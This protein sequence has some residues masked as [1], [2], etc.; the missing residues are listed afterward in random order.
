MSNT[1]S[2]LAKRTSRGLRAAAGAHGLPFN[3]R[4]PLAQSRTALYTALTA[5]HALRRAV[6]GL[7]DRELAPLLALRAAGGRLDM[8]QFAA[9]FG[10]LQPYR[11]WRS[12]SPPHP[13]R[14]PVST[15]DRLWYLGLIE[16]TRA[17]VLLPAEVAA[18]L[19][20]PP[21]PVPL[22]R[23][24]QAVEYTLSDALCTDVAAFIGLLMAS[25]V[26]PL[27]GR[28]LP[29]LAL[30]RINAIALIPEPLHGVRSELQTTRLRFVH[31]LA[32]AAGLVA[33]QGGL[34]RP[35]AGAWRWL[36]ADSPSRLVLL[37]AAVADD[38]RRREPLWSVYRLPSICAP[39][40]H[41]AAASAA[42]LPSDQC[43]TVEALAATLRPHL[44]GVSLDSLPELVAGPL[45]W[46]GLVTDA[47][48][49]LTAGQ[50][51]PT[52][53]DYAHLCLTEDA[54]HVEMPLLPPLRPFVELLAW[55]QVDSARH[56]RV[57][58]VGVVRALERGCPPPE[59]TLSALTG[60]PLSPEV[61]DRL[62]SWLESAR[63][64]RL[65]RLVVLEAADSAVLARIRADWR[66]RPLLGPPLSA[67]HL[68][69]QAEHA[70]MLCRKLIQR[71]LRVASAVQPAEPVADGALTPALAEYLWLAARVYQRLGAAVPQDVRLPGS[72]LDWLAAQLTPEQV[73]SLAETADRLLDALRLAIDGRPS[74]STAT[75]SRVSSADVRA[76]VDAAC[77]ISAPL[78]IRYASPASGIT[79][80]VIEPL[81]RYTSG[82]V[83]YLEAWCQLDAAP[84]TFRLDR[85][86]DAA[87]A[88][89]ADQR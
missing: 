75:G 58:A 56:F 25:A 36:S 45:A 66:L 76:A 83:D 16:T 38:L 1:V 28:W 33:V 24:V 42:V 41:A 15:A 84:R 65:R 13:W 14:S 43:L 85:I 68:T 74:Q 18:L 10:P 49:S 29:L 20:P 64:L 30:R 69:V 27:H 22:S 87:E 19:P 26:R 12:D 50:M 44:P 60:A 17:D 73:A 61:S 46:L 40:W 11:P 79:Q 8:G 48:N 70:D 6:R 21:A 2:L 67:H 51:R 78:A 59:T 52:A 34:L 71:G 80:R 4:L 9:A 81:L 63:S 23:S 35:T 57:D 77:A 53:P 7:T 31:Y 47:G 39:L 72:V 55:A 88:S 89:D 86:L 37:R 5:G 62:A 3:N 54:I 82:G 32:E